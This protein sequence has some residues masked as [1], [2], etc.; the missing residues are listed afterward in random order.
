MKQLI[1][2]FRIAVYVVIV[3]FTDFNFSATDIAAWLAET[4]H[5]ANTPEFRGS[6]A[7]WFG[8][9]FILVPFGFYI[10]QTFMY[11]IIGNALD[12]KNTSFIRFLR[13]LARDSIIAA[14]D[15]LFWASS[16]VSGGLPQVEKVL[17]Y[18]DNK[19]AMMNNKDAAEFM[20]S[21]GH[22]DMLLSR[23]DLK[24]SRKALSYMNNKM[25]CMSN[26]KALDY[27]KGQK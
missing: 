17:S 25:A 19:M 18:R 15:P 6:D 5:G 16:D 26:E 14:R 1:G 27:L 12:G 7:V 2:V 9:L 23:T 13:I 8:K 11:I 24:Q 10:I 20:R 21:T 4:I 22:V 3:Q